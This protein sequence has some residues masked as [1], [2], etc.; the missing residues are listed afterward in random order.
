LGKNC[1]NRKGRKPK[2]SKTT[3]RL[4]IF[5]CDPN[6]ACLIDNGAGL[7]AWFDQG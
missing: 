5:L 6:A 7:K 3:V 2:V 1:K 4:D